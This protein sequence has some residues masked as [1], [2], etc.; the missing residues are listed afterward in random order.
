MIGLCLLTSVMAFSYQ[1]RVAYGPVYPSV[2]GYDLCELPAMKWGGGSIQAY[3]MNDGDIWFLVNASYKETE[4]MNMAPKRLDEHYILIKFFKKEQ[5]AISENEKKQLLNKIEI[6]GSREILF[7][8][9]S[10][11][12]LYESSSTTSYFVPDFCRNYFVKTSPQGQSK[13]YSIL[14]ASPQVDIYED[15]LQNNTQYPPFMYQRLHLLSTLIPLKD[16]TF[17]V[18]DKNRTLILRVDKN[19]KTQFK[20]VNPVMVM[21]NKYIMR[22]FFIVDYSLISNLVTQF[23]KHPEPVYQGVHN[24]LFEHFNKQYP[25]PH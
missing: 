10:K 15:S 17:L 24:A 20:P 25:E 3:A 18:F 7:K 12:S 8:D 16:D 11:L 19:L 5:K 13:Q 4:L 6:Q 23:M 9:K 14:I 2:W 1:A 22:N 21:S